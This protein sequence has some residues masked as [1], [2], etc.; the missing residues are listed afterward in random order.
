[1]CVYG[2]IPRATTKKPLQHGIVEITVDIVK[3]NFKK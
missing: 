1:M 2:V 3:W